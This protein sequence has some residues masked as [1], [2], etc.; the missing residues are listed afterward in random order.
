MFVEPSDDS[1]WNNAFVTPSTAAFFLTDRHNGRGHVACMDG[2]VETMLPADY[3][4]E[5]DK[6]IVGGNISYTTTG[7]RW[8]PN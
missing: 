5:Q 1:A 7:T 3:K 2:H 8:N 4:T 6:A